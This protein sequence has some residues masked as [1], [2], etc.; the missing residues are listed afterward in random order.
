MDNKTSF[1]SL[2]YLHQF[3]PPWHRSLHHW[4]SKDPLWKPNEL[5]NTDTTLWQDISCGFPD[6]SQE[7]EKSEWIFWN[8]ATNTVKD[9]LFS[10]GIE[11]LLE[12][13]AVGW[14]QVWQVQSLRENGG[15][16]RLSC[17]LGQ[18]ELQV[19]TEFSS[20]M[21]LNA[22]M[23]DDTEIFGKKQFK[24]HHWFQALKAVFTGWF[25]KGHGD[26]KLNAHLW[27]ILSTVGLK[28]ALGTA[29]DD[30]RDFCW[31]SSRDRMRYAVPPGSKQH[32]LHFSWIQN[33]LRFSKKSHEVDGTST[34]QCFTGPFTPSFNGKRDVIHF[35]LI[36]L[37]WLRNL[38][39]LTVTNVL[40]ASRWTLMASILAASL[41][42]SVWSMS[43]PKM[44]AS[45][46]DLN[47]WCFN[48]EESRRSKRR[49]DSSGGSEEFARVY[50]AVPGF[51]HRSQYHQLSDKL[52]RFSAH[53]P[54][55]LVTI[56][57]NWD[58]WICA[59]FRLSCY[60]YDLHGHL[61]ARSLM[62]CPTFAQAVLSKS[63]WRWHAFCLV[64]ELIRNSESPYVTLILRNSLDLASLRHLHIH[65]I[66]HPCTSC[67]MGLD[68]QEKMKIPDV[69]GKVIVTVAAI[70]LRSRR[71]GSTQGCIGWMIRSDPAALVTLLDTKCV[72]FWQINHFQNGRNEATGQTWRWNQMLDTGLVQ[73]FGTN[74]SG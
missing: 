52:N 7:T 33:L 65:H 21:L 67:M 56:I 25:Q 10:I 63:L 12:L 69:N 57:Y 27:L 4:G 66:M 3:I 26:A 64:T 14:S 24:S 11:S 31:N 32:L 68:S 62:A 19:T 70:A 54:L 61:Y 50:L 46:K 38:Q 8:M 55:G 47:G 28:V 9:P 29:L 42:S 44:A 40:Y 16:D 74:S 23:F 41:R 59:L 34:A 60:L 17:E 2:H 1:Q 15:K 39:H 13:K 71:D 73:V 6:I 58:F 49:A 35:T 30:G 36:S 51:P 18:N 53:L 5:A 37:C 72:S 43:A 45:F 22:W 20:Q 48:C